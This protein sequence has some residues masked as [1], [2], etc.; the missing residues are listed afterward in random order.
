MVSKLIEGTKEVEKPPTSKKQRSCVV[1]GTKTDKAKLFRLVRDNQALVSFD[2]TGKKP[3]RGAYFCSLACLR[4]A[5]DS[6]R[7]E[8][9]LRTKVSQDDYERIVEEF[10]AAMRDM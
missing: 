1:C 9:A 10:N 6:K 7:L 8:R 3:G 5:Y 2:Q 4:A